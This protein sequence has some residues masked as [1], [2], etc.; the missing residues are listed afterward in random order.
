MARS[1]RRCLRARARVGVR[2]RV[3][4]LEF[5]STSRVEWPGPFADAVAS[6]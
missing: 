2:V 4:G 1:I 3:F 6:E 5:H